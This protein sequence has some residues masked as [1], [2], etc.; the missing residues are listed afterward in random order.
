M[1]GTSPG[2]GPG[3]DHQ[4]W[5][6]KMKISQ[7][8]TRIGT[9]IKMSNYLIHKILSLFKENVSFILNQIIIF[10]LTSGNTKKQHRNKE[11]DINKMKSVHFKSS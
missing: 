8:Q 11:D 6:Q 3:L 1:C 9:E 5:D 2:S 10:I 7:D 4:D